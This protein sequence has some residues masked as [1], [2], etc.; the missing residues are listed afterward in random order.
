MKNSDA[1]IVSFS[2]IM[3]SIFA[4]FAV[5]SVIGYLAFQSDTE[6]SKVVD[7]GV[8]LAFKVYPEVVT[9]LPFASLWSFLFFFMLFTLGLD[10]QFALLET[11]QTAL[12]DRFPKVSSHTSFVCVTSQG[13]LIDRPFSNLVVALSKGTGV[14]RGLFH[15]FCPWTALHD[16]KRSLL[17]AVV[18]LVRFF[19]LSS[20]SGATRVDYRCLGLRS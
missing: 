20:D 8:G 6:V 15:Q 10:S 12:L 19:L 1:L 5:F 17:A 7:Q 14:G 9:K 11:V 13:P 2:N 3:T 16:R 4:G 18:R